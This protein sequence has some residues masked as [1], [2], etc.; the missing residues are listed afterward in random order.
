MPAQPLHVQNAHLDVAVRSLLLALH[1]AR[2]LQLLRLQ[3][4]RLQQRRVQDGLDDEKGA[5]DGMDVRPLLLLRGAHRRL[6]QVGASREDRLVR[7]ALDRLR[8]QRAHLSWKSLAAAHRVQK[9][10]CLLLVR[11]CC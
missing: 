11:C 10:L 8:V 3:H 7:V 5:K 2:L 6:R 9:D 1:Q 4:A